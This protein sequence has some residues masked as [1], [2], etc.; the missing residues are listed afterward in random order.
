[1]NRAFSAACRTAA[2]FIA[3]SVLTAGA[4]QLS[5]QEAKKSTEPQQLA[6]I[7]NKIKP[8]GSTLLM[9]L[10]FTLD[11]PFTSEEI[12]EDMKNWIAANRKCQADREARGQDLSG[13]CS[14]R[15]YV[16]CW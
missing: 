12:P 15:T 7:P 5:A 10:P 16:T 14:H 2:L 11:D 9:D 6:R 8:A 1:M 4:F 3:L 13:Q